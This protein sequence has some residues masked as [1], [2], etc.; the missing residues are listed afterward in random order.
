LRSSLDLIGNRKSSHNNWNW[1]API[2]NPGRGRKKQF[3]TV[4]LFINFPDWDDAKGE[5]ALICFL[6]TRGGARGLD[7][8]HRACENVKGVAREDTYLVWLDMPLSL[9]TSR[10][11]I[12]REIEERAKVFFKVA[13]PTLRRNVE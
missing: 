1:W 4:G 13:M 6:E 9:N 8:L 3:G 12:R 11:D 2:Y 7:D 5:P 10:T